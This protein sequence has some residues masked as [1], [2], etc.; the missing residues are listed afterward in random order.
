MNSSQHILATVDRLAFSLVTTLSLYRHPRRSPAF[1][2][3]LRAPLNPHPLVRYG[4]IRMSI[5]RASVS[6]LSYLDVLLAPR[7]ERR[8]GGHLLDGGVVGDAVHGAAGLAAA[9]DAVLAAAQPVVQPRRPGSHVAVGLPCQT[10]EE[11]PNRFRY[12]RSL[13]TCTLF[14]KRHFESLCLFVS[15]RMLGFSFPI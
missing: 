11:Q 4:K 14:G 9:G 10:E 5:E 6:F 1:C 15:G 3:K 8:E 2:T 12:S 13:G 7:G